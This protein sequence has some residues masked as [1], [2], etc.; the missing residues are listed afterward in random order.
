MLQ[1][2]LALALAGSLGT[3][4]RVGLGSLV[5]RWLGPQFPWGTAAVNL[6]GCFLFGLVWM[7]GSERGRLSP[8]L[9]FIV[10]VG[11]MGAFTTFSSFVADSADLGTKGRLWAALLNVVGQNALGLLCF[12]LGAR[13]GRA[14]LG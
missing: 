6:L 12:F 9:R 4:A 5:Q 2:I 10:L 7:L 13:L 14:A 11:F 8:E 3:L 1:K